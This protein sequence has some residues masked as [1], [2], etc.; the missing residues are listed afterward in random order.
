MIKLENTEGS[1]MAFMHSV[2][3]KKQELGKLILINMAIFTFNF[4][5]HKWKGK[6][7][8]K[9]NGPACYSDQ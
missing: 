3:L 8:L 9:K 6:P 4:Q 7:E 2:S 5:I 1:C